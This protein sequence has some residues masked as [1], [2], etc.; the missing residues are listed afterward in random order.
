MSIK[1]FDDALDFLPGRP[2]RAN[3]LRRLIGILAKTAKGIDQGLT[4]HA[5]YKRHTARGLAPA[6]AARKVLAEDLGA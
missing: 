6:E 2:H 5:N 3:G 1:T 4:A